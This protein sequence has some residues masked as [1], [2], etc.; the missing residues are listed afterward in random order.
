[1]FESVTPPVCWGPWE[2][3]PCPPA[4]RFLLPRVVLP[5][6][7]LM[8][9]SA[10]LPNLLMSVKI[11]S[12]QYQLQGKFLI[13]SHCLKLQTIDC[14]SLNL[15]MKLFFHLPCSPFIQ[16]IPPHLDTRILHE[17]TSKALLKLS[18]FHCFSPHLKRQWSYKIARLV[19]QDFS[20]IHPCWLFPTIFQSFTS[21]E[22][23]AMRFCSIIFPGKEGKLTSV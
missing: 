11:V 3:A 23:A 14:Y 13:N 2:W 5:R 22:T 17:N 4:Y 16:T 19:K 9:H 12:S 18:G 15:M 21:L 7:L 20:F 10:S 8:V 6:N 1:M